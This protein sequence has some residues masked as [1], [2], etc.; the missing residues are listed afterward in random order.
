[1]RSYEAVKARTG[2]HVDNLVA[3]RQ[4]R[5]R[6]RVSHPCERFH[7]SVGKGLSGDLVIAQTCSRGPARVKVKLPVG[8]DGDLPVL[9]ANLSAE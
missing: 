1:M 7:R 2:A 5:Y 9:L 3:R 6:E 8:I 4:L